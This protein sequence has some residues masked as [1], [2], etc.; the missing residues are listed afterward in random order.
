MGKK[1]IFVSCGQE[2]NE[3]KQLGIDILNVIDGHSMEGFFAETV[4]SADELNTAIF[5]AIHECDGFCAVLHRRG[6]VHY[7]NKPVTPRSSVWIQQEIAILMFRRFL[8]GR[9]VPIR[10]FCENGIRREGV[11]GNSIINPIYFE[12]R[13]EVLDAVREWLNGPEFEDDIVLGRREVLFQKRIRGLSKNHW[14]ILELVAAH[15]SSQEDKVSSAEV[16]GDFTSILEEQG[17]AASKLKGLF[18]QLLKLLG[19]QGLINRGLPDPRTGISY[20]SIPNKWSDLV[21]RELVL[22][23]RRPPTRVP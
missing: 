17:T 1:R 11:I 22:T 9:P 15:C 7:L 21:H 10:V 5:K 2:T 13:D 12:E 6:E 18:D 23:S 16:A 20:L 8:Q 19:S 3:E 14:L 4:H